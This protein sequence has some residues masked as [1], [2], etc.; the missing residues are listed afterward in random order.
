MFLC[1]LENEWPLGIIGVAWLL[2][3]CNSFVPMVALL[4][5]G[6]VVCFHI[7]TALTACHSAT[8]IDIL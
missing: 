3:I 6:A 7:P 5:C 2:V 8:L 4:F 1:L